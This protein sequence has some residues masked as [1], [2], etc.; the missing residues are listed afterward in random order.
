MNNV[1][2]ITSALDWN[3]IGIAD[4]KVSTKTGLSHVIFVGRSNFGKLFD[5]QISSANFRLSF[6]TDYRELWAMQ[7]VHSPRLAV[8]YDTL[9]SFELEASCRL[10][11]RRWPSTRILILRAR[12]DTVDKS[13]YDARLP[14]NVATQVLLAAIRRLA[15]A[16]L[17]SIHSARRS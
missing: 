16:R 13:L 10:I 3:A 15:G 5:S 4:P 8:L 2:E 14:A 7:T 6:A 12:M 11:R 17:Y 1:S 9:H